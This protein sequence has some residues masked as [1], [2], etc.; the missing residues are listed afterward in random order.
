MKFGSY[1]LNTKQTD[2][3]TFDLKSLLFWICISLFLVSCG[4]NTEK[5]EVIL[6]LN[7]ENIDEFTVN[8]AYEYFDTLDRLV[9]AFRTYK[10]AD[11]SHGF[12]NFKNKAWNREYINRKRDYQTVLEKNRL[13]ISKTSIKPLFDKFEALLYISLNLKDSLLNDSEAQSQTT[14][15]TIKEDKRVVNAAIKLAGVEAKLKKL[16]D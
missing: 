5:S 2:R 8:F 10:Q 9:V 15:T 13:Y 11:D 3:Q 7:D 12:I 1:P 6:L 14:L 4:N 16:R